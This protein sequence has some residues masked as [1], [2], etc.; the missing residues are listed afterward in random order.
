MQIREKRFLIPTEP[1]YWGFWTS[2]VALL[3]TRRSAPS[4]YSAYLFRSTDAR[5][6]GGPGKSLLGSI[7]LHV[8]GVLFILHLP[9]TPV[10]VP[11]NEQVILVRTADIYYAL[12]MLQQHK[13]LPRIAPR[14]AGGK[15][16]RGAHPEENPKPGSL[17]FHRDLTVIS[18]PIHPDNTHQTI[19]Q[20]SSP[21]DLIIKQDLKLPNLVLGNPLAKPQPPLQFPSS[22]MKPIAP[23]HTQTEDVA[24]PQIATADPGLKLAPLAPTVPQPR[25]LVPL[26]L[27]PGVVPAASAASRTAASSMTGD[28]NAGETNG[29]LILG[30]D[31]AAAGA[32]L[33]LPPGNKYGSF[34]ISPAGGEP[35]APGGVSGGIAGAGTGGSGAGGDESTGVGVGR[36]G[37]GGG[38]LT[39]EAAPVSVNGP[40][41]IAGSRGN[42]DAMLSA[43]VIFP[44]ITLPHIH[45]N[46]LVVSAGSVGGGGL[47]VYQALQCD[48]IYTIFM[49]MQNA[50]WTLQYCQQDASPAKPNPSGNT[51]VQ[52]QEGLLPPDPIEK[53]DFRRLPVP[54]DKVGKMI[55]LK[56]VIREDGV[57]D[58]L[59][60]YQ[61]VLKEMDDTAL[62]A[63]SKWK[64]TPA[65]RAGKSV[66]V[67][68]LVGIQISGPVAH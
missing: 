64:F 65:K 7:A 23:A 28:E 25:L 47:G 36:T 33:S 68:I 14:G 55:V 54:V 24:A 42:L 44:V 12:A 46:A 63:L 50:N 41:A 20:P 11:S 22:P 30:T 38:G 40:G 16:G 52:L 34:S 1:F 13:T 5:R 8:A 39:N 57:V 9:P 67:Q 49:P 26:A 58:N 6:F 56:G 29:L 45:R 35:G 60:V 37:G 61:G 2:F 53:F 18:N 62:A 3:T 51:S 21:P 15:P 43:G 10:A 48:R 59:K 27:N 32:S 31:P 4:K 19:I 17:I 66:P